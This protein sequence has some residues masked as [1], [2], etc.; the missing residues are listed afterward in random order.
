MNPLNQ[1]LILTIVVAAGVSSSAVAQPFI[2]V[3]MGNPDFDV[4]AVQAAVDQGGSVVLTGY[5]SFDRPAT[6]P[7]GAIYNRMV[8]VS[9]SIVISGKPNDQGEMPTIEAGNWPFF[10]DAADAHVTI[11][12]LHFLRPSAGAIWVYAVSELT[13]T[14]CRMESLQP[15]AEFAMQG[16]IAT[17]LAGA[18]F[19]SADAHPA[20]GSFPGQPGNFYGTLAIIN[21]DFDV[22]AKSG[23]VTEAVVISGV[24]RSPDRE[25][26]I[27]VSGNTIRNVTEPAIAFRLIGGRVHAERNVIATG[28]IGAGDALRAVGSG[29]Y[30]I[31]H[32]SID[33][34]WPD[35]AATGINV[36]GNSATAPPLMNAIVVDNDVTMSAPEGTAFAG[37]SA[38]IEIGGLAHGT[39]VLNNRIHGRARAALAVMDRGTVIPANS[40][41]ISNDLQGFQPSLVNMFV[42]SGVINTVFVGEATSLEDHGVG[43]VAVVTP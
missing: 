35:P 33:C 20:G 15:T 36:F 43:T 30:L 42:D 23:A 5:F 21:N 29:S 34:G 11:R 24:G 27:Y 1:K 2:V 14:N 40:T 25:V 39:M 3:G 26:D 7:T 8:T 16:G 9:R 10:I 37:N 32:N 41:F 6:A 19:V 4:P 18:I 13:I 22:G 38:G 17:P 31:A 28:S 12:G